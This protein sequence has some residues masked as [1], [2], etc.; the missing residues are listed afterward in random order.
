MQEGAMDD[1]E[2]IEDGLFIAMVC[3][4]PVFC[5][6]GIAGNLIS[7]RVL[8]R[9]GLDKSY[10]VLLVALACAD[11]N[12]LLAFFISGLV[13]QSGCHSLEDPTSGF[14][15]LYRLLQILNYGGA[16][17]S[18]LIP[19]FITSERIVAVCFPLRVKSLVS[20]RRTFIAMIF[21]FVILFTLATY[22]TAANYDREDV[23]WCKNAT[24]ADHRNVCMINIAIFRNN[25]ETTELNIEYI[26]QVVF[27][28]VPVSLVTIGCLFLVVKIIQA[29]R[30]RS[31]MTNT[32]EADVCMSMRITMTVLVVCLVYAVCSV[33]LY[34][35]HSQTRRNC[36]LKEVIMAE[37][38]NSLGITNCS[39]NF[40]IYVIMN[41][42]YRAT[43]MELFV[44]NCLRDFLVQRFSG[45]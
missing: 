7:I 26:C 14:F 12:L 18:F 1:I 34:V 31:R 19:L 15:H 43:Y 2:S 37:V 36:Q 28:P 29:N 23:F 20:T 13:A 45:I 11:S 5:F 4:F 21:L 9:H 17:V 8:A 44:P 38:A 32:P 42:R 41:P 33:G 3:V 16:W 25:I 6:L 22:L 30:R 24:M 27:G 35:I 10:N 40:I 39:A